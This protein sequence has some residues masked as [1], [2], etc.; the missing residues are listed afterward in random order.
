MSK[1]YSLKSVQ[2]LPVTIDEAWDFFSTPGNLKVITPSHLGFK[3][4]SHHHGD[5]IYPGQLIQYVIK[6]LLGIPVRWLTE[7]TQVKDKE[8]FIDEQRYGPYNF[9]HHQHIFKPVANGVEMI[10]IV[11]YR[12]PLG[13]I[14]ALADKL[15]IKRQLKEIFTFRYQ[16]IENRFGKCEGQQPLINFFD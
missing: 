2:R 3:V 6:P 7:I 4:I 13:F 1:I 8:F 15:F 12:P 11:H 14:G 5:K 9:W 10:D 16:V